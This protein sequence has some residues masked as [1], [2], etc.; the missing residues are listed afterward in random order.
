VSRQFT[1]AIATLQYYRDRGLLPKTVVVHLGTNGRFGDPEFDT[2]MNTIGA[3]RQVFFLTARVPRSW[4]G[5]VNAHLANGVARHPNAHLIDWRAYSTC[6]NDWFAR[7]QYHVD[8]TGAAVYADLVRA[9]ISGQAP[10][11]VPC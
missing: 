1:S 11:E 7:D 5:D 4:E 10:R 2:M 3:N 9:A 8:G 6:H